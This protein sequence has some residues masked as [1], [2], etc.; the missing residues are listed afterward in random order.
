MAN[1]A[2][3]LASD[4]DVDALALVRSVRARLLASRGQAVQARELALEVDEQTRETDA[5]VFRADTLA[6]L[7]EALESSPAEQAAA[8]EE[9]R[10]LYAQKQHLV[11]VARVESELA[12]LL[13][14]TGPT[15][16]PA[17]QVE[18]AA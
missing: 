7:A 1:I 18:P 10:R 15:A 13:T 8:L 16:E 14:Q 11:G 4:D 6:D 17:A 3:E 9:A 12:R 5:P 2:A